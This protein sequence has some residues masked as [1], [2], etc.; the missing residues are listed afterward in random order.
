MYFHKIVAAAIFIGVLFPVQS[1]ALIGCVTTYEPVCGY[2]E[3]CA[4]G[5]CVYYR[6]YEN[7]CA[8]HAVAAE[9]MHVGECEGAQKAVTSVQVRLFSDEYPLMPRS[10]NRYDFFDLLSAITTRLMAWA[11]L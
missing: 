2:K 6:T 11:Y 8:M 4:W 1:F 7:S 10:T 5:S 3:K 9:L